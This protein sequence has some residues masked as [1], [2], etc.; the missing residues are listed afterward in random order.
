VRDDVLGP[1]AYGNIMDVMLSDARFD[2]REAARGL[3]MDDAAVRRLHESGHVIGLHSHT[4]PTR[5][6]RLSNDEQRYEYRSNQSHL[7]A[8]L[9]E[10]P[11]AMS[12]PCNSYNDTTLQ[13]LGELGIKL[14]FRANMASGFNSRLELPREDHSNLLRRLAA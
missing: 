7:T 12:H 3:W 10:P 14:G 1:N 6:Q 4:H 8:L 13:I 2:V 5:L 9:G 11:L